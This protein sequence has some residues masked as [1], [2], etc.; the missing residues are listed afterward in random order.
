MSLRTQRYLS[1]IILSITRFT[2]GL[3]LTEFTSKIRVIQYIDFVSADKARTLCSRLYYSSHSAQQR[4]KTADSSQDLSSN[5][6]STNATT[7]AL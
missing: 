1:Y 2:S 6:I 7:S 3:L 4:I 5:M